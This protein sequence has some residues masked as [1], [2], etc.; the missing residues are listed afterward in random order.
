MLNP[1]KLTVLLLA[2]IFL[3]TA[4]TGQSAGTASENG[5]SN[6]KNLLPDFTISVY[7]GLN[8]DEIR[9]RQLLSTDKPLILNFWAGQCPPC[10]AEMPDIQ[11]VHDQYEGRVSIWGLD[12]GPFTGLGSR[13]EGK[14]L[15]RE[16]NL[17]YPMGT[18][19]ESSVIS[20]FKILGMPTTLFIKPD[21]QIETKWTGVLTLQKMKELTEDL[22]EASKP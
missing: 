6:N 2:G 7:Q 18:T 19:F 11:E 5:N 15:I 1:I 21:G 8:A 13:E 12:V 10:K 4:C 17:H 14:R 20:D 9:V 22:L 16:L 3:L